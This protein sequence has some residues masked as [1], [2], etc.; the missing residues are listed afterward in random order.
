M[1][2]VYVISCYKLEMLDE[3]TASLFNLLFA[4]EHPKPS[5]LTPN[6]SK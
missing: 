5:P 6:K 3:H 1:N 2:N 4:T